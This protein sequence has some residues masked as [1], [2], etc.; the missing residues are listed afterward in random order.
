MFRQS[1]QGLLA[2]EPGIEPVGSAGSV[3]AA[4]ELADQVRP[5]VVLMDIDLPGRSGIEGT[6]ELGRRRPEVAVIIVTS[7][8]DPRLLA[9]ALRA[10]AR[11]AVL[12]TRG[13]EELIALIRLYPSVSSPSAPPMGGAPS[14]VGVPT[15]PGPFRRPASASPALIRRPE[16]PLGLTDREMEVLRELAGGRSTEQIADSLFISVLTVRSHVKGILAKLGVH[17]KLEAVTSAIQHGLVDVSRP[18]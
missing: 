16:S 17:S 8:A 4:L 9:E 6:R 7:N 15:V 13:V 18:A 2:A 1:L 14:A 5:D 10:G 12:K 11:G 3:G